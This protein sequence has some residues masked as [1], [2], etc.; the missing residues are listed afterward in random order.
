[1]SQRIRTL[2]PEWRTDQ[3]LQRAGLSARVLSAALITM[4]DDEGRGAWR[5]HVVAA[6]VFG[7]E[8]DP[9]RLLRESVAKLRDWFV[10]VYEVRGETYFQL[11]NW[12]R[13]QRV[14]KP[15]PSRFPAPMS[16]P[17][18]ATPSAGN[19]PRSLDSPAP[20]ED[21]A[22]RSRRPRESVATI[23]EALA[24]GP[25]SGPGSGS[26]STTTSSVAATV[27][28]PWGSMVRDWLVG[29]PLDLEDAERRFANQ[30]DRR[31]QA[32]TTCPV[33]PRERPKLID[34][35]RWVWRAVEGDRARWAATARAMVEMFFAD[36]DVAAQ[37]IKSPGGYMTTHLQALFDRAVAG[38]AAPQLSLRL[39]A[40]Q[41]AVER[42]QKRGWMPPQTGAGWGDDGDEVIERLTNGTRS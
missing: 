37:R 17:D 35:A 18:G 36:D 1:M 23:R 2:K 34:A 12:E 11:L 6:D 21:V 30:V 19:G 33:A 38:A 41:A 20:R 22:K 15:R 42:R 29:E 5:D 14:D 31:W 40:D 39:A 7:F 10:Q 16:E 8:E 4:A 3:K 25:G 27:A 13:H 26:G 28:D 32:L 9:S 24:P